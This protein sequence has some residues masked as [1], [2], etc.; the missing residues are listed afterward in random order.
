MNSEKMGTI[1]C[2]VYFLLF[3][4]RLYLVQFRNKI[5]S[6]LIEIPRNGCGGDKKRWPHPNQGNGG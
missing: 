3:E 5:I 4:Y 1:L 2:H 6:L